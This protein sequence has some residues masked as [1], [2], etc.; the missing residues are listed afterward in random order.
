MSHDQLEG[1]STHNSCARPVQARAFQAIVT[2]LLL[3]TIACS[4]SE[5][6]LT[7]PSGSKCKVTLTNSADSAGAAGGSGTVAVATS[8]D[9]T[10][11]ASSAAPWIVIT[12][13]TTGQGDGSVAYRVA[14]NRDPAPRQ[15]TID[16]N[17]SKATVSQEAAE[18]RFTVSPRTVAVGAAGGAVTLT[19]EATG[20]CGWTAVSQAGWIHITSASSGTGSGS[21]TF[22][23]DP[24][25]AGARS[26]S[27]TVAGDAITVSQT[28]AA[29]TTPPPVPTPSCTYAILPTGQTIVAAG[30]TGSIAVTAGSTCSW[31]ASA[32]VPWITITSGD[33]GTG[34]GTVA[35]T[36]STNSGASRSGVISAAGETFIVSQSALAC[37][38]S[39]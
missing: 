15:A 3:A 25:S 30:G 14:A 2:A 10:W 22:T 28:D 32:N 38:Y 5:V 4:S 19:I 11:A 34:P 39:I 26:A 29:G 12:S 37:S 24:N 17:A 18:C 23:V 31:T 1:P 35:F 7:G 16:I 36:V 13:A 21:I 27:L 9:C 8:R 6:S 20:N 33:K